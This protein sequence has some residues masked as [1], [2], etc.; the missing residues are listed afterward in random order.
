MTCAKNGRKKQRTKPNETKLLKEDGGEGDTKG[1][2]WEK[3]L[4]KRGCYSCS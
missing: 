1:G 4:K 2:R 3:G